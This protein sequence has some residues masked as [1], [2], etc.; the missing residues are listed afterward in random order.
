MCKKRQTRV[1]SCGS[2]TKQLHFH[3]TV[4]CQGVHP[5]R[6]GEATIPLHSINMLAS[7]LLLFAAS[8][9]AF[10]IPDFSTLL[11]LFARH[12]AQ[13]D[14]RDGGS[15]PAVWNKVSKEL[16]SKFLTR[17]ECNPDARAAIRLIFHD[18]GGGSLSSTFPR[19]S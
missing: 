6:T 7:S 10:S 16:T 1:T 17:G 12:N 2:T 19:P 9:T 11:P 3:V 8:A 13:L 5:I 4:F 18:C 15:C 14:T